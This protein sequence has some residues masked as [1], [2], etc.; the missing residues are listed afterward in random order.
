LQSFDNADLPEAI[1][2]RNEKLKEYCQVRI[3]SYETIYKSVEEETDQYQQEIQK[4]NQQIE[5]LIS[6]ISGDQL[7]P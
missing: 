6:E 7:K 5:K 2:K 1:E 4:Y 3:K